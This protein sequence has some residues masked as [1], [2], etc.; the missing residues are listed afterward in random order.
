MLSEEEKALLGNL[1]ESFPNVED[2]VKFRV[3][4]E[5][6]FV[7][8]G[9]A[10]DP[11]KVNK[12]DMEQDIQEIADTPFLSSQDKEAESDERSQLP[13]PWLLCL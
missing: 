8:F 10:P 11:T 6:L 4:T 12:L 13:L 3:V 9:L 1:L 5:E 7:G 2:F